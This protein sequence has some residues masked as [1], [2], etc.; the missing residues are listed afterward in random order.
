ML[1]QLKQII[2]YTGDE[3]NENGGDESRNDMA[4]ANELDNAESK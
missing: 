3:S 1:V 2:L 4:E